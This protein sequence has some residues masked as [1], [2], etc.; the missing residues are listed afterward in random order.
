LVSKYSLGIILQMPRAF[1]II[2]HTG[3]GEDH[4]DLMLESAGGTLRTWQVQR[5]CLALEP[6]ETIP[7]A[8]LADHRQAYLTYEGP[9][10]QGRGS[11]RRVCEGTVETLAESEGRLVMR[12]IPANAQPTE[13]EL[14]CR[15]G[16]DWVLTRRA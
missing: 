9:V 5:N 6:G 3:F 15:A 14:V 13:F 2:L 1:V 11:V 12:L 10:S 16:D 7:A 4:F 8:R